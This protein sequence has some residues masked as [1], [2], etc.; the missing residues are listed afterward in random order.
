MKRREK[1][2]TGRKGWLA[3][4]P[5]LTGVQ[6][7]DFLQAVTLL[8]TYDRRQQDLDAG[9]GAEQASAV[10]C[11]RTAILNLP[12]PAYKKWA[13][14]AMKGTSSRTGRA[15]QAAW[16]CTRGAASSPAPTASMSRRRMRSSRVDAARLSV[17]G[18]WR[19]AAA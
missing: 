2:G 6:E 19:Q 8:H 11:K 12:L 13:E 1:P 10:S 14:P 9:T 4:D 18:R 17:R 5:V 3:K 15:G 16:A 7:T